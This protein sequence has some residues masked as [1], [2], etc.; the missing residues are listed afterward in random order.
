MLELYQFEECPH[1]AKVRQNLSARQIDS[2]LRNVSP[3]KSN[4]EHLRQVSG[5]DEVPTLDDSDRNTI[6][7][8]DEQRIIHHLDTL[9]ASPT[10]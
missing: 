7:A 2:I 1:S 8:G 5:Q 4:R 10:I 9:Y 3:D 6:I